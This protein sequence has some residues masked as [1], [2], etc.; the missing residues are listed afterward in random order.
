MKTESLLSKARP[1]SECGARPVFQATRITIPQLN[2]V[3]CYSFICSEC[4]KFSL[5]CGTIETATMDWNS[6]NED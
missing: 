2:R 1:C 5:I 4:G 3:K 6:I